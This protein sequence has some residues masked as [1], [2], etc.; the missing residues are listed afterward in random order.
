MTKRESAL[1]AFISWIGIGLGVISIIVA[2]FKADQWIWMSLFSSSLVSLWAACLLFFKAA[3]THHVETDAVLRTIL[4]SEKERQLLEQS[5][6]SL[7]FDGSEIDN[8]FCVKYGEMLLSDG[9]ESPL[10]KLREVFDAKR[11]NKIRIER[12]KAYTLMHYLFRRVSEREERYWA[13]ATELDLNTPEAAT[14]L[15]KAPQAHPRNIARVYV[16]RSQESLEKLI[17]MA[18]NDLLEQIELGAELKVLIDAN[19][20]PPN[21]GIYGTLAVG[22]FENRDTNVFDFKRTNVETKR[23]I[24]ETY[25]ARAEDLRRYLQQSA[26]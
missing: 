23:E 8:V 6:R 11:T 26:A 7:I 24:F 22:Q 19:G 2:A 17:T 13:L 10:D 4:G 16:L 1:Y 12:E 25:R 9:D 5:I 15:F 18:R 21:F 3:R 14:F 20:S